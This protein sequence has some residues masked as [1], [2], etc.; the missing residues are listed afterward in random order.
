MKIQDL[1]HIEKAVFQK[2]KTI[3]LYTVNNE[4]P[5]LFAGLIIYMP[6]KKTWLFEPNSMAIFYPDSLIQICEF[7]KSLSD[8]QI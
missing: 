8:E 3:N 5:N 7:I 2:I 4:S 1:F 6:S